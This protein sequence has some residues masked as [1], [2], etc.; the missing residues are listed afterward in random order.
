MKLRVSFLFFEPPSREG[1]RTVEPLR[2]E[3]AK[4]FSLRGFFVD[5]S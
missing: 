2:R 3:D 4:V 1:I 5:F